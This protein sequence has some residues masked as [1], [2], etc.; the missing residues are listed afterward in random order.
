[1]TI[2][3]QCWHPPL[4]RHWFNWHMLQ[5]GLWDYMQRSLG[6]SDSE[7][8]VHEVGFDPGT[9]TV[10]SSLNRHSTAVPLNCRQPDCVTAWLQALLRDIV[11]K[12]LQTTLSLWVIIS[13][14]CNPVVLADS[15]GASRQKAPLIWKSK[16]T[17]LEK[18]QLLGTSIDTTVETLHVT[19]W[20]TAVKIHVH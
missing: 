12:S 7:G 20:W 10:K 16:L 8:Q 2:C 19:V 4:S 6:D 14:A 15:R 18:W 5:P 3:G 17:W 1:M 9:Q 11:P 13:S